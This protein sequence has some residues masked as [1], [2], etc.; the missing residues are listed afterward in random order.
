MRLNTSRMRF[1][2][3]RILII[4]AVE[5]ANPGEVASVTLVKLIISGIW[6]EPRAIPMRTAKAAISTRVRFAA[7]PARDIKAA[8]RLCCADQYGSY[9]ALAQPII[10]PLSRNERIGMITIPNGLLLMWGKGSSVARPCWYAV[11]SPKIF[12]ATP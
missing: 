5:F 10:Q 2:E 4:T 6:N 8:F 11:G 12:A 1:S 7:G 9:G 3:N